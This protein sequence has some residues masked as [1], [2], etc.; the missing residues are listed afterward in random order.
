[1]AGIAFGDFLIKQV[2]EELQKALPGLTTFVTLS[3]AP[4]FAA[5]LKQQRAA[6]EQGLLDET[7]LAA[8]AGLDQLEWW[9]DEV[10]LSQLRPYLLSA[11]AL[12]FVMA[13][14]ASGKAVDPVARFH[15]GNGAA[16]HQLNFMGDP[17]A[18]GLQQSHG[19]M[20][21]YLYR[22]ADIEG[23]HERFVARGEVATSAAVRQ[24]L[25]TKSKPARPVA[26]KSTKV[27]TQG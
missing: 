17:S 15:L 22:L 8:L 3:P 5:W 16:L 6:G 9:K 26:A 23:N 18:R 14:S 4:G 20:V 24:W 25:R 12:Y 7:Q 21:N 2:V 11:A 10:L 19:L 1:L 13:K 27:R